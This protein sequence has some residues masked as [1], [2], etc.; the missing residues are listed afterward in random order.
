MALLHL[1]NGNVA[2]MFDRPPGIAFTLV[3]QRASNNKL[4]AGRIKPCQIFYK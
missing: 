3:T 1:M 4:G 2:W